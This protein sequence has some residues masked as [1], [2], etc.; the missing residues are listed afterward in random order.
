MW[1][2]VWVGDE[3]PEGKPEEEEEEEEVEG[4]FSGSIWL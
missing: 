2:G 3:G 4:D 1:R